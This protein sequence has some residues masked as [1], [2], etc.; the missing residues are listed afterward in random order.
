MMQRFCTRGFTEFLCN[1]PAKKIL[2]HVAQWVLQDLAAYNLKE[3]FCARHFSYTHPE[4]DVLW[5]PDAD[6]IDKRFC[7]EDRNVAHVLLHDLRGRS[8]NTLHK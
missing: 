6:T 3:T 1:D 7:K 4:R 5:R 2:T 8:T